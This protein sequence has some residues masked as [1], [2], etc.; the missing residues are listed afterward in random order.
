MKKTG[1][2]PLLFQIHNLY[3]YTLGKGAAN[4]LTHPTLARVAA[5]HSEAGVGKTA[6]DVALRWGCVQV[7]FT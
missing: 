7:A 2:K 3:R 1:F 6:A 4:L 5:A